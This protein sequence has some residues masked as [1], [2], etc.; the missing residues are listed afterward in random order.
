MLWGCCGALHEPCFARLI[1]GR[2]E[3]SLNRLTDPFA[4]GRSMQRRFH[5]EQHILLETRQRKDH[6]VEQDDGSGELRVASSEFQRDVAPHA[7]PH[8]DGFCHAKVGTEPGDVNGKAGDR[9]ALLGLVALA[10]AS[11]I[12][13]NSA[14]G[15]AEMVNLRREGGMIS[16]PAMEK[17]QGWFPAP[18]LGIG[19]CDTITLVRAQTRCLRP[20][21][22]NRIGLACYCS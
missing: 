17:H 21:S 10:M 1:V 4:V 6:R 2:Q 7:V 8:N 19:E 15:L 11:Q 14:M 13:R 5:W 20:A 9:V 3:E 18:R 16:G 12:D 22:D